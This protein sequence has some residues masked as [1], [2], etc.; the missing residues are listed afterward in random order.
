MEPIKVDVDAREGETPL[1]RA[2][3]ARSDVRIRIRMLRTGDYAVGRWIGVERKTAEDLARSIVDGR[4]F[5]QAAA[6]AGSYPR[7]VVLLEG[8]I[9]G[10]PILN[11]SAEAIRGALISLAT[12]FRVPVLIPQG[13]EEGAEMIVMASRQFRKSFHAG[14]VRAGYRPRGLRARRLF[15]L[16]GL[17]G[18]GPRRATALLN[19]F[20]D[21]ASVM[22]AAPELLGKTPSIGPAVARAIACVARDETRSSGPQGSTRS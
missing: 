16:Q 20:G 14:Y 17:P 6:L 9:P 13:P 11:V 5:R 1:T 19:R 18:V 2:L 22:A 12:V 8:F 7:P 21:P 4:L 3:A 15:V 10:R